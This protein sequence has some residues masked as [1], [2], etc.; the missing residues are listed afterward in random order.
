MLIGGRIMTM[1]EHEEDESEVRPSSSRIQANVTPK[2]DHRKARKITNRDLQQDLQHDQ[3]LNHQCLHLIM[4]RD[5]D[6]TPL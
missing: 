6:K 5:R 2:Q 3:S 4:K 1:D